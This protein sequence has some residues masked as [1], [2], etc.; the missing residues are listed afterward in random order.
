MQNKRTKTLTPYMV[1]MAPP[2]EDNCSCYIFSSINLN[3]N[4]KRNP[5]P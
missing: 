2:G 5:K 1:Y 3:T 4:H